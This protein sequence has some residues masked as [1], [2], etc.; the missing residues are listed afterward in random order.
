MKK[1]Y[2]VV[3]FLYSTTK[4][5]SSPV[6]IDPQILEG[7]KD[8][9]INITFN[10]ERGVI[11]NLVGFERKKINA[12]FSDGYAKLPIASSLL[13]IPTQDLT[14][15][16]SNEKNYSQYEVKLNMNIEKVISI[17][18][19]RWGYK[20]VF[21]ENDGMDGALKNVY[22]ITNEKTFISIYSISE[23]TQ[24]IFICAAK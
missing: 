12:K 10:K 9:S 7:F 18:G 22:S 5:F 20:F 16:I 23:N 2:I 6:S 11:E 3:C 24:T 4:C 15:P 13:G 17:M 21:T 8:C 1:L 14:I 19:K